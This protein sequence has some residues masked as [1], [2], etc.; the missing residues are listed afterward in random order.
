MQKSFSFGKL[1]YMF[2]MSQLC[3]HMNSLLF[4]PAECLLVS[5]GSFAVMVVSLDW[6]FVHVCPEFLLQKEIEDK[7][8]EIHILRIILLTTD[9][10]NIKHQFRMNEPVVGKKY[11]DINQ[12]INYC[13]KKPMN[14]TKILFT[15]FF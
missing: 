10:R 6:Q 4:L 12:L 9:L 7:L 2:K 14:Q 3:C 5:D 1:F 15:D 11:S 8:N 13:P